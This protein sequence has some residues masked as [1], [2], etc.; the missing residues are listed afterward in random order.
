MKFKSESLEIFDPSADGTEFV[1]SVYSAPDWATGYIAMPDAAFLFD[2]VATAAPE[3]IVEI[4]VAS[5][6]STVFLLRTIE[7]LGLATNLCSFDSLPF[8]YADRSKRVG[9]FVY[10]VFGEKPPN[11]RLFAEVPAL[12]A[13]ARLNAAGIH[14]A[15]LG[16]IDANHDHPWPCLDLLSVL[17]ALQP[18][19]WVALHDINLPAINPAFPSFGPHYL[20]YDWP[21]PSR[22]HRS[23]D[24]LPN[25]GAI[26]LFDDPRETIDA[27]LS[28]LERR[29]DATIR[30]RRF[31]DLPHRLEALATGRGAR[32]RAT[33]RRHSSAISILGDDLKRVRRRLGRLLTGTG[34]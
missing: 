13:A 9:Q 8:F 4:G 25:I 1:R 12:E 20:F 21:G 32:F 34:P 31:G 33:H 16:F 24:T 11:L 23:S 30:R 15:S 18:G 10:D 27:V 7:R 2:L 14:A 28:I 6:V 22:V 26:R 29:W 3:T 17:P 19:A 5:G